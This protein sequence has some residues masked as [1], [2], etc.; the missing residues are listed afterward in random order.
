MVN[1][2][3]ITLKDY[4]LEPK[5]LLCLNVHKLDDSVILIW[6]KVLCCIFL[7]L[8]HILSFES[9]GLNWKFIRKEYGLKT[10]L[11]MSLVSSSDKSQ[12]QIFA[13]F[14]IKIVLLAPNSFKWIDF[15]RVEH[16]VFETNIEALKLFVIV[17]CYWLF[18]FCSV[19]CCV[20]SKV[21]GIKFPTC[22]LL[23]S[24]KI[25]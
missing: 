4:F 17:T 25:S 11:K 16:F 24:T 1:M 3:F 8:C 18:Q 6:K 20:S 9:L 5:F 12:P 23:S 2:L 21:K 7:F 22:N 10:N 19:G 14:V 13:D 15:F